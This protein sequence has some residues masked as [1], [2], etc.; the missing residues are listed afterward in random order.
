MTTQRYNIVSSHVTACQNIGNGVTFLYIS[1][2]TPLRSWTWLYHQKAN[3]TTFPTIYC[4]Y[5]DILNFSR[6]SR[7]QYIIPP[8]QTNGTQCAQT[9]TKVKV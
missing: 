4:P 9:H 5:G 7:I 8:I 1:P 2:Q 3:K 6:M